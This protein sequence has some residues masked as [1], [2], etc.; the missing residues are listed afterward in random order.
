MRN[1]FNDNRDFYP[2]PDSVIETMLAD[3]D[4]TDKV[5]LEP[6]AGK[7]NIVKALLDRGAK[8]VLACENDPN[9]LWTLQA[10]NAGSR[11]RFLKEDF[12]EVRAEEVAHIDMIVMNPPFSTAA[13]HILHAWDIAPEGCRIVALCNDESLGANDTTA[14]RKLRETIAAHGSAFSLGEAF[15]SAERTTGVTVAM[16]DISRPETSQDPFADYFIDGEEDAPAGGRQEGLMPYD[17]VRDIV[18]RYVEACR[19]FRQVDEL[20]RRINSVARY[21]EKDGE[22][23]YM[24]YL[25]IVFG[26]RRTE[27]NGGDVTFEVYKKELQKYYWN[28]IFHKLNLEKYSTTK[29]KVQLNRFIEQQQDMPF[30]MRNIYALL[31][32]VIQ[33]NGQRMKEALVEAFDEICSFSA[34]N[35][36]AGE[37][38]KT[39]SNYMINRR[40]IVPWMCESRFCSFEYETVHLTYNGRYKMDDI[41]K[42]LCFITGRRFEEIPS[43]WCFEDQRARWGEWYEWGF[44]RIRFYKKGTVHC[45]FLDEEVWMRFNSEVARIRGWALPSNTKKGRKAA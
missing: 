17:A 14:W 39:N 15:T 10:E 33:T 35:S 26:A 9:L 21:S 43:L 31:D 22:R 20:S 6:S 7:G 40:F 44:F 37:K 19:M 11:F 28:V 1:I 32:A 3:A 13:E 45:E 27:G 12:L 16:I 25:P 30:T 36:T 4:V 41:V 38:W 42:A 23:C 18:S 2:T 24:P 34:D 8:E 5:V 29:L